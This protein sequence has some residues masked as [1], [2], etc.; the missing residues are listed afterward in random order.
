MWPSRDSETEVNI[1]ALHDRLREGVEDIQSKGLKDGEFL[2]VGERMRVKSPKD[3]T[4]SS[5]NIPGAILMTMED[6]EAL[7]GPTMMD[8][9]RYLDVA[10]D[11]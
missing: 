6:M 9:A 10:K 7:Y 5:M 8:V 2:V 3:T 1:S 11:M 4:Q